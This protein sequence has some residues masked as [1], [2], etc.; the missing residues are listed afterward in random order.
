[1]KFSPKHTFFCDSCTKPSKAP[2][3]SAVTWRNG[4]QWKAK[5]DG[6]KGKRGFVTKCLL[7]SSNA[8]CCHIKVSGLATNEINSNSDE[9]K[10]WKTWKQ[11]KRHKIWMKIPEPPCQIYRE[12]VDFLTTR[13]H[14]LRCH[15]EIFS[16]DDT[17][18]SLKLIGASHNVSMRESKR[19]K[20]S[21]SLK[22]SAKST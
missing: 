9:Q 13:H 17:L 7:F 6:G 11:D 10:G 12:L 20:K 4:R 1:M 2:I 18:Q 16:F 8:L 21:I 3:V 15:D 19:Q 14:F 22:S 5:N